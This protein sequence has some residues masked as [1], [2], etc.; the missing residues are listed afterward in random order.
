[1][2]LATGQTRW[3]TRT[4]ASNYGFAVCGNRIFVSWPGL[5][6]LD[7]NTG[8]VLYQADEEATEYP[9]SGLVAH[10]NRVFMLGNTAAYGYRC[11]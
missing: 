2:D 11:N 6:V 9:T 8:R 3:K 10:G 7:R 5:S 1:M 4:P